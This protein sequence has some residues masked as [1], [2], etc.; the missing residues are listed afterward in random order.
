MK[1]NNIKLIKKVTNGSTTGGSNPCKFLITY[2]NNKEKSIWIDIWYQPIY[3]IRGLFYK[4][5]RGNN[6]ILSDIDNLE[7]SFKMFVKQIANDICPWNEEEILKA[8]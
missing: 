6:F 3:Y 1:I 4:A 7:E 2:D 8:N 5:L